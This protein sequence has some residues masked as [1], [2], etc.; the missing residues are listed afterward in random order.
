MNKEPITISSNALLEE[1]ATL[2]R[3]NEISF[4]PVIDDDKLVGIITEGDIFDSFIDLLGFR[5]PG[6]RF[7]I[8]ADDEPGTISNLTSII[9]KFGANQAHNRLLFLNRSLFEWK[10]LQPNKKEKSPIFKVPCS[11]S[12][13]IMD[14]TCTLIIVWHMLINLLIVRDFGHK[15]YI[16]LQVSTS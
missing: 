13:V 16:L 8:E 10:I 5:E 6:T 7:T 9:G 15:K 12:L 14:K 11:K 4:L 3:D 1:A 2:M